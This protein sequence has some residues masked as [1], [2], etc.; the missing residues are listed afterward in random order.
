MKILV[1]GGCGYIGT[2]LI[3]V[4]LKNKHK[5]ISVDK[6]IFGDY[7]PKHKNLK[8]LKL[9]VSQVN[10]NILK[11]VDTVMHLAAISNDPAAILNSKI[12]WETNVLHT[13]KL[14]KMCKKS[15]INK[16]IFASSG[17]VYGISKKNRVDENTELLPITDYN[18]TKMVG[19]KLV[20]NFKKY[21]S[22]IIL[23]PGTVCGYSDNIRLDLTVNAMTIDAL[24]KNL[25]SVN[26]GKQIRPQLH[27]DDMIESYLFFLK[28]NKTGIFNVGFE[29]YSI[30]KIADMINK[31]LESVKIKKNSSIDVRSYRLYAG[32]I[33]SIGFKKSKS[34]NDAI[35]DIINNFNNKKIK[36]RKTNFR[37][38]FLSKNLKKFY[39]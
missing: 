35:I 16:F 38:I 9:C 33:L 13:L 39:G 14:L 37:S 29:N 36:D 20:E 30:S 12:T 34:S 8:N 31:N 6:K 19:E 4:L 17:S 7:L 11:G 23:R 28:N 5:V 27:I 2:E 25:I 3:K 32:K 22:T 15:K 24:K 10:E 18:K 21:F 1:T 26:G